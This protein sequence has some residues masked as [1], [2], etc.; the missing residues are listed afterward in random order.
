MALKTLFTATGFLVTVWGTSHTVAG[1]KKTATPVT[2]SIAPV[3]PEQEV[4]DG[5]LFIQK[6]G[7]SIYHY[8][9]VD[10]AG[11]YYRRMFIDSSSAI[12]AK[13]TGEIPEGAILFLETWFGDSQSTVYIRQKINGEWQSNSFI[14][15]SPDYNVTITES[16]NSCHA[17]A[18]VTDNTYT[19]PL[20]LKSLAANSV[21]KIVCDQPSF[22]PCSLDIYQGN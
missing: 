14:P 21:Q 2:E 11:D 20:L 16:C 6:Y 12:I 22:T 13:N 5:D 1:C 4:T 3:I 8:A 10:K 19:Q 15:S 18:S 17:G 9:E 7:K